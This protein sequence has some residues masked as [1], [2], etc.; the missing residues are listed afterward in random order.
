MFRLSK[1]KKQ[2]QLMIEQLEGGPSKV[3]E[4]QIAFAYDAELPDGADA[5]MRKAVEKAFKKL[6]GR[7]AEI[8]FSGWGGKLNDAQ[9]E[10]YKE[11]KYGGKG[12]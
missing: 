12:R 6:L 9:V 8:M 1:K 2:Q 10:V 7:D 5:P 11:M 4:C 3:W